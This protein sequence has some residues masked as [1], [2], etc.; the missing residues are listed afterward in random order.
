MVKVVVTGMGAITPLGL[1]AD[2]LWQGV[3]A[4]RTAVRRMDGLFGL[5]GPSLGAP[6]EDVPVGD[7]LPPAAIRHYD[8]FI[9]LGLVAAK[10]ALDASG[11]L[12]TAD[13][14]SVGVYIGCAL[15]GVETMAADTVAH[16]GGAKVGPRL[17]P[18]TIPNMAAATIAE[19]WGLRGPNVTFSTACSSANNAIGEAF[20]AVA[21]G[22]MD[23]CIAGGAESLYADIIMSGLDAARA[24][25]RRFDDPATAS[26]PFSEGRDGMVMGEG[27]AILVLE[28][29]EHA[30]RRG[31]EILGRVI[32]YGPSADAHHPTQP[33]PEGRGAELAMRRALES[34]GLR[35]EEIDYINAH[36]TSTP[37]G[38][39]VECMAV[40]RV[41]GHAVPVS[42]QKGAIGH[43]LGAAG[44]A[45]AVITLMALRHGILPPTVNYQGGGPEGLDFVPAPRPVNIRRALSNSFG[46]GGQ[47]ASIVLERA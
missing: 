40:R 7:V 1:G 32:G 13:L 41:F 46:F 27:A 35:P 5:P 17:L 8:R 9:H 44:A 15:G 22:R 14:E 37:I 12:E 19:L 4:G 2:A 24:L 20:C 45:E 36:G 38:D 29:E 6:V 30:A 42:S 28:S 25:S 3:L 43:L 21:A 10:Q 47:N 34:A 11:A 26:R 18:K 39:E 23:V 33:H 31:A 16:A